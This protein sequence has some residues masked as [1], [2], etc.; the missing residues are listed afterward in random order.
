MWLEKV[1][2]KKMTVA[3]KF[4][5]SGMVQGVGFRFFTQRCAAIHQV[6]G[7]VLNLPDGRVEAWAEGN[8]ESLENFKKDLTAG[9]SYSRVEEVEEINVEPIGYSSF[10]IEL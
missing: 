9:P 8:D 6:V 2:Q 4:L 5:I 3:R 10:R 7:Y 1:S